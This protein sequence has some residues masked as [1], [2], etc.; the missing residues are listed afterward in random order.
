[1]SCNTSCKLCPRLIISTGV[2][3]VSDT[4]VVDIPAGVYPNNG[5]F[6]LVIAQNI[7]AATTINTPVAISIGGET[8]TLYPMVR[9]NCS[10]VTACALRTR[11]RYPLCV[12]TNATSAVFKVLGNLSCAPSN[13]LSAVPAPAA[14]STPSTGS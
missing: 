6:C 14:P 5:R 10:Q 11:T 2:S 4:L 3:I 12:A 8:T 9:C 7:P 1:M 13:R